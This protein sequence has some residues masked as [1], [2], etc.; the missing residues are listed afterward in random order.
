[1][2]KAREA[3]KRRAQGIRGWK[4]KQ[5]KV[6]REERKE[7]KRKVQ[8]GMQALKEIQ[9]YQKGPDLLIRRLPFQQ[10]VSEIAQ[11]MKE[12]LRFQSAAVLVMQEAEEAF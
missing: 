7:R 4:E 6:V 3:N 10:L 5:M 8:Q 9:K 12:G 2:K 11:Q 1:M